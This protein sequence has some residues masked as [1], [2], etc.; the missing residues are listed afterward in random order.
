MQLPHN[1]GPLPPPGWGGLHANGSV[2]YTW[3]PSADGGGLFWDGKGNAKPS[4]VNPAQA[5]AS[6]KDDVSDAVAVRHCA[7]A[8]MCTHLCNV[9]CFTCGA[10]I[11][12]LLEIAIAVE[13]TFHR[14]MYSLHCCCTSIFKICPD[15]E[16]RAGRATRTGASVLSMRLVTPAVRSAMHG[17]VRAA[18]ACRHLRGMRCSRLAPLAAGL[19]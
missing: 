11:V 1:W 13:A 18:Q 9:Q 2:N 12:S 15:E 14:N 3:T 10:Y 5:I 19:L 6:A 7:G 8:H 16:H 17:A 4:N